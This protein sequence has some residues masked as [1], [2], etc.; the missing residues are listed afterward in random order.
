MEIQPME[1][2][3]AEVQSVVVQLMAETQPVVEVQPAVKAY[4]AP[5]VPVPVFQEERFFQELKY[6]LQIRA[7]PLCLLLPRPAVMSAQSF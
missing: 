5:E 1:V 6:Y 3:P 2:Q 4:Q 7:L